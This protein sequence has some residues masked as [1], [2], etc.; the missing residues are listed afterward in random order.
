MEIQT[1]NVLIV[2]SYKKMRDLL[3]TLFPDTNNKI[4]FASTSSAI[5]QLLKSDEFDYI[6]IDA[7]LNDDACISLCSRLAKNIKTVIMLLTSVQMKPSDVSLLESKGIMIVKKPT[8]MN[9][10]RLA[11]DWLRSVHGHH[12]QSARQLETQRSLTR[13]K[14]L[15]IEREKMTESEAHRYIEKFS[16][17]HSLSKRQTAQIIIDSYDD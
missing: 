15:L 10:L 9:S 4:Q 1:T 17:D 5:K 14:C 16:M 8:T 13:A 7:P 2:S 3:A 12:I 6:I 11:I